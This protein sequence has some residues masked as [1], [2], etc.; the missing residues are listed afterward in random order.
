MSTHADRD[1]IVATFAGVGVSAACVPTVHFRVSVLIQRKEAKS[2][3]LE[4]GEGVLV[5]IEDDRRRGA[6]EDT[7]SAWVSGRGQTVDLVAGVIIDTPW[8]R[9]ERRWKTC[10]ESET[11]NARRHCRVFAGCQWRS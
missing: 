7:L 6:R 10:G 11:H 9:F 5:S 1:H 4:T 8:K 3:A 2:N